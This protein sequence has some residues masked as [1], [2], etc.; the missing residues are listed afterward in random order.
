MRVTFR[1]TGERRYAVI[2]EV[3]GAATQ[4][5]SPAP[6]FDDHIPHDLV[7]YV[8]EAALGFEGGVFGRAARGGGTF[9]TSEAASNSRERAR[10]RR[11]QARRERSLGREDA[12][13]EQL[14]TSERLAFLS[15][16]AWRR[17]QGQRPDPTLPSRL[18]IF[19]RSMLRE[20]HASWQH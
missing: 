17:R 11:K 12:N 19:P 1:R 9:Y 15:D 18:P 6:G 8:V 10:Q 7:H 13:E 20:S 5:M 3:P 4:T 14:Q 2:V 16:I